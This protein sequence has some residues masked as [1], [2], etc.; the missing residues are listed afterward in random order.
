MTAPTTDVRTALERLAEPAPHLRWRLARADEPLG[1]D[2]L[3]CADLAADPDALAAAVA[4]TAA[5][6]GSD[7]PQVLASLWW[8][9]YAYRVGG[10]ALACWLLSGVAPDPRADGTA[11]GVARSRPSSVVY[12]AE[13]PDAGSGPPADG[14]AD[15]DL[16]TLVDR[17][18]PGHLDRVAASLRTRHT[19]GRSLIWGNV[20]AACAAAAGAVR[21]AAGPGW[22]GRLDAF[23]A[24]APHDLAWL[25]PPDRSTAPPPPADRPPTFR[26]T[27]HVLPVV[28]DVRR[29]R[30]PVRRL[31]PHPLPDRDLP[32]MIL[33]LSNAD[34]ELLALGSIVHRL[35]AGFPA[36]RAANPGRLDAAPDLDGV[37][38]VVVRLL[39]GRTA[40]EPPSTSC[41][42]PASPPRSR[43]SPSGARP[44]PTPS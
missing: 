6:R 14:P 12:R 5:G 28:E 11:V 39:G 38:A 29:G 1:D 7:D 36:V 25:R 34:T 37:R 22:R 31:L 4:A 3:A 27:T 41:A 10:T 35:P 42:P 24:A 40:W 16:A 30:R 18:F 33:F 19:L 32:H 26:R 23:L 9:A 17:L 8:Q 2:E 44:S 13:T 43:S 20:A 21:A 15:R